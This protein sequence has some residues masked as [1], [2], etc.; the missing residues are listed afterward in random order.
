MWTALAILQGD[1]M[2]RHFNDS[3]LEGTVLAAALLELSDNSSGVSLPFF[4]YLV[5]NSC[6]PAKLL[7]KTCN[8]GDRQDC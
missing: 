2:G 6:L 3:Y 4:L 7:N 1:V 5:R 8:T